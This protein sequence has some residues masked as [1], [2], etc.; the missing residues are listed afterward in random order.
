[1]NEFSAKQLIVNRYLINYFSSIE[2]NSKINVVFVH[3]WLSN[4]TVW[5]HLMHAL[6]KIGISSYALDLPGF[7]SSQIPTDSVDNEFFV[8]VVE[9]FINICSYWFKE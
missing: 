7:G 4:A 8:K 9:E 2:D 6:K 1:M 3:G 5:S